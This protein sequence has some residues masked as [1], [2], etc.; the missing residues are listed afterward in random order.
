MQGGDDEESQ[1]IFVA[2]RQRDA[3]LTDGPI[4]P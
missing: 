3:V 4:I 1:E 2:P